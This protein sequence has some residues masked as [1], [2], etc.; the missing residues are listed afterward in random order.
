VIQDV[1]E[2]L[3]LDP[4]LR[5]P[6]TIKALIRR[7]LAY[8]DA[9]KWE[10]AAE[11]MRRVIVLDPNARQAQEALIRINRNLQKKKEWAAREKK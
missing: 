2:V 11:D 3:R 1:N 4:N 5:L 10:L 7:G 9:E 8:E 6:S